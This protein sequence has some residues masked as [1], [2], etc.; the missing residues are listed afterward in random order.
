[1]C[2][3][4]LGFRFG[5][6][7]TGRQRGSRGH[8]ARPSGWAVTR[9]KCLAASKLTAS[10]VVAAAVAAAVVACI[11]TE[12]SS[13]GVSTALCCGAVADQAGPGGQHMPLGHYLC[14]PIKMHS[15][16]YFLMCAETLADAGL[17]GSL[18]PPVCIK[19]VMQSLQAQPHRQHPPHHPADRARAH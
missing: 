2:G 1:M 16:P 13:M 5:G 12:H 9:V 4:V 19:H 6:K 17:T 10:A 3:A 15:Q 18:T 11:H 8:Q 7:V 14:A